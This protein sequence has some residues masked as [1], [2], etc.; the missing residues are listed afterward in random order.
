MAKTSQRP[1]THPRPRRSGRLLAAVVVALAAVGLGASV[2]LFGP[3]DRN[4][5]PQ[6]TATLPHSP[7]QMIHIAGGTFRMGN[8]RSPYAC[9]RPS[10]EVTVDSFWLDTHEVTN[11]QF[12]RFVA[13]TGYMTTAEQHGKAWVFDTAA[14]RWNEVA[15]ADWQHPGG[16]DTTIVH[17][18]DLP[19]VQVSW[20][21]ARAY[22]QWAGKRL[23]TEAEWEY[24]ARGG[25]R[26]AEFSWGFE[27]IPGGEYQGN[28]W[29]GWFPDENLAADG[30]PRMAPVMSFPPN[31][32]ALY[33]MSG[34]VWEWCADRFAEDAY[35]AASQQNP[36]GPNEGEARV[37]RGGSWLC[38]ENYCAGYKV[39]TRSHY[40]PDSA[41]GHLG[42]RCVR[43]DHAAE[44]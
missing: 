19:V 17:A 13:R 38:A 18:D 21:D 34:N 26:E 31:R 40:P 10:H 7:G 35:R 30:F 32:Y 43:N 6:P 8:D 39:S 16:P 1:T 36:T 15:G 5:K 9:E 33:D 4:R 37:L 28:Y 20:H 3:F 24:A 25:L 27:E 41:Y 44:D 14:G 42:F 29:Q 2:F 12:A 22:A 23:P 11:R